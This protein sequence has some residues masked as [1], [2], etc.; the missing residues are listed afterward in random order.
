MTKQAFFVPLSFWFLWV[1]GRQQ[2]V[3][4]QVFSLSRVGHERSLEVA[5][6]V[7]SIALNQLELAW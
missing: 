3:L 7:S 2:S 5:D 1:D 4:F 6:E